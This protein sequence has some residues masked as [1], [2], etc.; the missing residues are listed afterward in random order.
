MSQF[1]RRSLYVLLGLLP[2]LFGAFSAFSI[3]LPGFWTGASLAIG[4]FAYLA[5]A[6]FPLQSGPFRYVTLSLFLGVGFLVVLS[7]I[8]IFE[9]I[10]AVTT[11][12]VVPTTETAVWFVGWLLVLVGPGGCLLHFMRVGRRTPNNSCMD[13]SVKQSLP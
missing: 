8:A 1:R 11:G 10:K 6:A 7:S 13:S 4:G 9:T 12:R 3:G 2:S 5:F